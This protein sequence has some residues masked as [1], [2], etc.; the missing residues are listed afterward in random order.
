MKHVKRMELSI[1]MIGEEP[2]E[3]RF[4]HGIEQIGREVFHAIDTVYTDMLDDP[5]MYMR[6]LM[7]IWEFYRKDGFDEAIE[8]MY[9]LA[10]L[11]DVSSKIKMEAFACQSEETKEAILNGFAASVEAK[12]GTDDAFEEDE[13]YDGYENSGYL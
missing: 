6:L 13:D 5:E 11:C 4:L 9:M 10:A 12:Y 2:E 1:E 7:E 3:T 8:L